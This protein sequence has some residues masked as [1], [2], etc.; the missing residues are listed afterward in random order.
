MILVLISV[1]L[2]GAV[3]YGLYRAINRHGPIKGA[4]IPPATAN[5]YGRKCLAW[6]VFA[7]TIMALPPVFS[8]L[9]LYS[10]ETGHKAKRQV[11]WDTMATHEEE[12]TRYIAASRPLNPSYSD[13]EIGAF[14]D[15]KQ[16][17]AT[18]PLDPVP[19][20]RPDLPRLDQY[21]A[22][23]RP[24]NPGYSDREIESAWESKYGRHGA[25]RQPLATNLLD[26][27]KGLVRAINKLGLWIVGIV[28]NGT[29][30]FVAGWIYGKWKL[31]RI[32]DR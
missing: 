25:R 4:S 30:G 29:L 1:G 22:S 3:A 24:L 12:R 10:I 23:S 26:T 13:E 31:R 28:T 2:A 18:A 27:D 7:T 16:P 8:A 9:L 21:L 20:S 11:T 32:S 5:D 14:F 15:Q 17:T 19:N 6:M